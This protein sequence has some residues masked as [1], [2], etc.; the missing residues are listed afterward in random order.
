MGLWGAEGVSRGRSESQHKAPDITGCFL[1][2]PV[3][4]LIPYLLCGASS[5]G[6]NFTCSKE[7]FGF[8]LHRQ[9]Q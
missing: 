3:D 6:N 5:L 9:D 1:G 7:T 8:K 4:T 2:H